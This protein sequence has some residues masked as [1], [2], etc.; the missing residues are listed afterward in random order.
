MRVERLIQAMESIAPPCHAAEWDNV[1][2]LVG[3][4]E[5]SARSVLLT[6]DLTE[7]VLQEAIDAGADAVVA[8]HPPIFKPLTALAGRD[9]PQRIALRAARSAVAVYSPHTAL[10]AAPGGVNDWLAEGLGGGDVRALEPVEALPATEQCKVVT[11]CPPEAVDQLRNG[12]ATAGAGKIGDYELCSFEL[13]GQGTFRGGAHT[14]PAVGRPGEMERVDEVRL[15]MVAPTAALGLIVVTLRQ[16]HP[17]EEP[18]I[19]IY[20][21]R[22]RPQRSTG[23]GRRVVLDQAAGLDEIVARCKRVMGV[24]R[25]LVAAPSNPAP[26]RVIGL[27]AGAGGSLLATALAQ[28]CDAFLTGEMRHHDVLAALAA[29]CAVILGGHTNT[30]RGYLPRLQQRL[31]EALGDVSVNIS[32]RDRDPLRWA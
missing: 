12:L 11:F 26:R 29:G 20:A 6:V 25:L 14:R 4:P 18:P 30:E 27:C 22:P 15:E 8:Y 28:G 17:Y 31:R 13:R 21:L 5:W 3:A 16:F 24:E 10:D 23:P 2:L 7:D 19:E 1:G 9:T 32:Q